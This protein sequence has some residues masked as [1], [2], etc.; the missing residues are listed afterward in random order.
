MELRHDDLSHVPPEPDGSVALGL[1]VHL[2]PA[3]AYVALVAGAGR[4]WATVVGGC[5]AIAFVNLLVVLHLERTRPCVALPSASRGEWRRGL[6]L[7]FA[8]GVG[9]GGLVVAGGWALL[10]PLSRGETSW[11]AIAAAVLLTDYAYYWSHRGLGH[12]AGRDRLT[13]WFRRH[14]AQHH[15]VSQLDFLRGNVSSFWD[16]AVSGFQLPLVLLS[17]VLGLDLL[18]TLTAYALV[19]MLQATHHLNHTLRLGVARWLFMDNHAHKL[20]HCRRGRLVNHGAL[21]SVWD[22]LHG[23]YFEAWHLNANHLA[24]HRVAL[25]IRVARPSEPCPETPRPSSSTS[26]ARG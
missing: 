26:Y 25:P 15:G 11:W 7:V 17:A 8:T 23:T 20:H 12:G 21:F 13:R 24:K 9:A 4:S 1:A 14:H 2:G 19:L 22:R 18:S 5:L 10:S 16:T 3:L 6:S